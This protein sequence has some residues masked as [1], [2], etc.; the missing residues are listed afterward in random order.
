MKKNCLI[1]KEI[2]IVT[3]LWII[4]AAGVAS[5]TLSWKVIGYLLGAH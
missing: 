5:I 2:I 4:I 3:F 1:I